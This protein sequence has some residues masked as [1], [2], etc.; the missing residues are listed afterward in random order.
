LPK[1]F[2]LPKELKAFEEYVQLNPQLHWM[3]KDNNHRNV[4][5]LSGSAVPQSRLNGHHF[6]Q[7]FVN[8]NPLLLD[9]RFVTNPQTYISRSFTVSMYLLI[10]SR[11]P[12]RVY[13]YTNH[14]LYRVANRE[15]Y[16][17]SAANPSRDQYV[18]DNDDAN[19]KYTIEVQILFVYS[20][21]LYYSQYQKLIRTSRM[22]KCRPVTP[23]NSISIISKL[24]LRQCTHNSLPRSVILFIPPQGK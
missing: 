18:I 7:Q 1:T 19:R 8:T 3:V 15:F 17:F 16:P 22:A 4:H 24:I 2:L 9:G 23:F 21:I 14:V 12:L 10:T 20:R 11:Q 13:T 5:L 6:V